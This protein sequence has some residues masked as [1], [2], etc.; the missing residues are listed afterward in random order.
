M[1]DD[2]DNSL[3]WKSLSSFVPL[4]TKASSTPMTY[5]GFL[6]VAS[7]SSAETPQIKGIGIQFLLFP[8]A[9]NFM[10]FGGRISAG[11]LLC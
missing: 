8:P 11:A 10:V 1:I 5:A 7:P 2:P 6:P 3:H 4:N 9:A